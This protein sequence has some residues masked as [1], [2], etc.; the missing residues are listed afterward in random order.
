VAIAKA[1][2]LEAARATP[3]PSSVAAYYNTPS[4]SPSLLD[5]SQN[6]TNTTNCYARQRYI[7]RVAQKSKLLTQYKSLLF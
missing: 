6:A 2:Q 4:S 3:V 1:L 5:R 7:Y